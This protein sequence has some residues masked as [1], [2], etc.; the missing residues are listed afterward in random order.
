MKGPPILR[1][2]DEAAIMTEASMKGSAVLAKGNNR[3]ACITV[4]LALSSV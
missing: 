4:E 1:L 2:G 3:R